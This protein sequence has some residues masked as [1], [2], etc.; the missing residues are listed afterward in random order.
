MKKNILVFP[1]GSEV[2]LEIYRS[3]R[4]SRFFNLI[5]ANSIDDHGKFVFTNYVGSLPFYSDPSFIDELKTVLNI[6]KIDAIYPATDAVSLFLTSHKNEIK[7]PIIS[8]PSITNE[9]CSSKLKTYNF[10]TNVIPTPIIFSNINDVEYFPIFAK[11][12]IGYGSRGAKK[13]I[14]KKMAEV[15]LAEFPG[16]I[17]MEYLPGKEYTIDCFTNSKGQLLFVGS[18]I[19]KRIMNGISVNTSTSETTENIFFSKLATIINQKLQLRG[20]WFFQMKENTNNDLVLL[21][22]ATRLGGSSATYR[23]QGVNFALLTLFDAF[24][25]EVNVQHNMFEVELD[26]A[27]YNRYKLSIDYSTIYI[28][29]DDTIIINDKINTQSIALI[30]QAINSGKKITLLTKHKGDL[31]QTLKKYRL[32]HLFD[33]IIHINPEDDKSS[34][35]NDYNA[36]FIDDSFTERSSVMQKTGL[37]VFSPDAIESL[38]DF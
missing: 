32:Q 7:I 30:Y 15:H 17:F 33:D 1:C 12:E 26:R 14:N 19:R 11:P 13:I 20:A 36:I 25:Y 9:I 4:H 27:L 38:I 8:S 22:I 34:F 5:G 28:D 35:V 21:E 29:L 24:G 16:T 23:I 6:N 18:R 10:F 31:N 37:P 2:A 3:V